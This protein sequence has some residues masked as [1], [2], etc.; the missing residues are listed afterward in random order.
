M[1][2][3]NVQYDEIFLLKDDVSSCKVIIHVYFSIIFY[4]SCTVQPLSDFLQAL[5]GTP[6]RS[7][8]LIRGA[9]KYHFLGLKIIVKKHYNNTVTTVI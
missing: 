6:K 2:N 4:Y 9:R 8:N 7:D 1:L 3:I 5:V